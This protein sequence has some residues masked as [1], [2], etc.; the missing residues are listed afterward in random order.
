MPDNFEIGADSSTTK[1]L[2]YI[3]K[4]WDLDEATAATSW[5]KHTCTDAS[6]LPADIAAVC[7]F[8]SDRQKVLAGLK[9]LE[10]TLVARLQAMTELKTNIAATKGQGRADLFVF[11]TRKLLSGVLDEEEQRNG[12]NGAVTTL[13]KLHTDAQYVDAQHGKV[14]F[15]ADKPENPVLYN[16]GNAKIDALKPIELPKGAPTLTG[17]LTKSFNP[18]LLK[19]GYHWKDPGA[20]D[21]HGEFTHR[22]QWYVLTKAWNNGVTAANTASQVFTAMGFLAAGGGNPAKG[23]TGAQ[24]V[25]LWEMVC[26]CFQAGTTEANSGKPWAQTFNCPDVLNAYLS[27][28]VY[29]RDH[30]YPVLYALIRARRLKRLAKGQG[31]LDR[32]M[33]PDLKSYQFAVTSPQ[34]A[35]TIVW[36]NAAK[37]TQ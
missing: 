13:R 1:V 8:L 32:L 34:E 22:L 31:W 35:G 11:K 26:D 37:K 9:N 18:I 20:G 23:A 30:D 10:D 12:F 15:A 2:S 27:N 6:K 36:H 14:T 16:P 33:N 25:Y 7:A 5:N 29:N 4:Y 24:T 19:N 21:S 17:I 28:P 3:K